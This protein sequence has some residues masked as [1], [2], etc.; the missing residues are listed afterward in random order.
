[1]GDRGLLRDLPL[2]WIAP[3]NMR[4]PLVRVTPVALVDA[5]D[6]R[7]LLSHLRNILQLVSK[8]TTTMANCESAN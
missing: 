1:M 6:L 7:R 4:N 5:H 2:L 8:P 3:P